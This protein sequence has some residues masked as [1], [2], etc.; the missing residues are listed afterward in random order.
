M[1][2]ATLPPDPVY[3]FS[4]SYRPSDEAQPINLVF[5]HL[6]GPVPT[7]LV[8]YSLD[9]AERL[10]DMLNARLGL[11]RPAWL[12]LVARSMLPAALAPAPGVH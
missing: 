12:A 8:A 10:C 6:P 7:G 5:E 9:E 1:T 2:T 11:D 4:P 3:C